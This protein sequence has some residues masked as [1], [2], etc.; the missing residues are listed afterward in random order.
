MIRNKIMYIIC[1]LGF[2]PKKYRRPV[3]TENNKYLC[4][5]TGK[6]RRNFSIYQ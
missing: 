2:T 5:I 1:Y 6:I 4:L 3:F